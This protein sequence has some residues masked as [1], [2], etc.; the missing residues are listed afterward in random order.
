[1]VNQ[2]GP[3][4]VAAHTWGKNTLLYRVEIK[5][6]THVMYGKLGGIFDN[7]RYSGDTHKIT[8]VVRGG[9]VFSCK[10]GVL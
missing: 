7:V 4:S 5:E 3:I 8:Y 9:M 10:M 1:M 2:F 6:E